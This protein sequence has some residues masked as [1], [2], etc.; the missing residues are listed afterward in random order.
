MQVYTNENDS[1]FDSHQ[2]EIVDQCVIPPEC[3]NFVNPPASRPSNNPLA[4]TAARPRRSFAARG[5]TGGVPQEARP[6]GVEDL[7]RDGSV[8]RE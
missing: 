7:T 3:E 2:E 5:R 8:R 6:T 1:Q 4:K